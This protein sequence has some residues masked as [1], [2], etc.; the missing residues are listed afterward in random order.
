MCLIGALSVWTNRQLLDTDNWTATS[1]KLLANQDV[2]DALGAYL[3]DQLFDHVDVAGAIRDTL[4]P[5]TQ[6][7]ASP[8]AAGVRAAADRAAPRL[9]ARP[10][11]QALWTTA[12]RDA[13]RRLLDVI[14]GGGPAVSTEGGLVTLDLQAVVGRL[15]ST[16]K[17]QGPGGQAQARIAL[18]AGTG[19]LVILRSDQLATAQDVVGS[20]RGLAILF[21]VLALALFAAAVGLGRGWRAVVLRRTG[22]CL[23]VVGLLLILVRR[24]GGDELVSALVR[25]P[26]DEPAAH[27]AWDIATSL[28]DAIAV[29]LIAYGVLIAL[30]ATLAGP[31]PTATR[32]R[33]AIAPAL[34]DHPGLAYGLVGAAVLVAVVVAPT[35]AFREPVWIGL[36]LVLLGLG[37]TVLRRQTARELAGPGPPER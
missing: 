14:D 2:D 24:V 31:G 33:R 19:E 34:R 9:L 37:V 21:P 6:G 20:I 16:L 10:S 3:V 7:L 4:P 23:V 29:G 26:S 25:S 11:V 30:A 8:A 36:L 5:Q 1:G 13:H 17:I 27:A 12:N 18:P 22:W 28:L 32:L 35:P 15:A